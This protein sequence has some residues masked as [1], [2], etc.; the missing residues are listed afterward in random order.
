MKDLNADKKVLVVCNTIKQSQ[1]VF[2]ELKGH[3]KKAVLLHG[4]FTGEDRTR[5]EKNLKEG[6]KNEE[7]PIQLLVGTQTIEVSLDIDYDIIYTEPAPIDALIQR[8][9]RVNRKREKG[10]S[11]VVIF[12]ERNS[13]DKYIYPIDI[14]NRTL[15]VFETIIESDGG[16]IKESK[17]QDYIDTVYPDWE[18]KNLEEFTNVYNLLKNA[19]HQLAPMIYSKHTEEEFYK[20]FDGI[21]VLPVALKQEY[22]QRLSNFDFIG[23][24]RLKVQIRKNKFA[25][26]RSE[27]S[28]NLYQERFSFETDKKNLL[29]FT[30]WVIS[31]K[32]DFDLGL[33]YDEQEKWHSEN[34]IL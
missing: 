34:T 24:E 12:K 9:G 27:N 19:V 21:K 32:Y 33:I 5:Y 31:K 13:N 22:E 6:E 8:F 23:A 14:I 11:P 30:Y 16:I 3:S 25:Q 7:E 26:L 17:L 1:D 29:S 15:K 2:L 28:N 4:A 20:Q 10:I 18:Q